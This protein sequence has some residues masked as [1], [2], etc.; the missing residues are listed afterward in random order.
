[1]FDPTHP[2]DC[3]KADV[4]P[5]SPK[6]IRSHT[7]STPSVTPFTAIR[8]VGLI[9]TYELFKIICKFN[10]LKIQLSSTCSVFCV[11]A[12]R[13]SGPSVPAVLAT[14][15]ALQQ[16][17]CRLL[18]CVPSTLAARLSPSQSLVILTTYG[19]EASQLFHNRK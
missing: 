4:L 5:V 14:L 6:D 11:A 8:I 17:C 3:S 2:W 12:P 18:E 7:R 19:V 13:V 10:Q 9:L 1:M 15:T 16:P